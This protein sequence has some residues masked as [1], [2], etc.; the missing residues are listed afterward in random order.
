MI[1]TDRRSNLKIAMVGSKIKKISFSAKFECGFPGHLKTHFRLLEPII[2][3]RK[4]RTKNVIFKSGI[5]DSQRGDPI[6]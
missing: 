1:K 2:A 6:Q 4:R 3:G 5:M